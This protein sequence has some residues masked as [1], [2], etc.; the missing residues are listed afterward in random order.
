MKNPSKLL[1][2]VYALYDSTKKV[3]NDLKV[4]HIR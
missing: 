2:K 1:W 3:L 4:K